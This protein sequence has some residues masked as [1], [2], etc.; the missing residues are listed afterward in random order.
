[1]IDI[2]EENMSFKRKFKKAFN[3]IIGDFNGVQWRDLDHKKVY[4]AIAV[5]VLILAL[6]VAFIVGFAKKYKDKTKNRKI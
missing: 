2:K 3:N 6:L 4:A 5:L 1:M